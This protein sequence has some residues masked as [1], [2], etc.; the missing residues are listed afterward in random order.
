[1][2]RNVSL[3]H[4]EGSK[5]PTFALRKFVIKTLKWN[6]PFSQ[7]KTLFPS[8]AARLQCE[9]AQRQN[10]NFVWEKLTKLGQRVCVFIVT[11]KQ[12]PQILQGIAYSQ[13]L[14]AN[15]NQDNEKN[16]QCCE[17]ISNK[18]IDSNST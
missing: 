8:V 18:S 2:P 4:G 5:E 7:S 12:T 1:M 3:S 9:A 6:Y 15:L 11:I 14:T 17:E 13:L 16:V 10:N